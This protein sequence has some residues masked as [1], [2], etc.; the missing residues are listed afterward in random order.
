LAQAGQGVGAAGQLE[1]GV[2]EPQL[3]LEGLV[4]DGRVDAGQQLARLERLAQAVVGAEAEPVDHVLG[5][6][7]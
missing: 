2:A 3:V 1:L 6:H 7:L 5:G 4:A